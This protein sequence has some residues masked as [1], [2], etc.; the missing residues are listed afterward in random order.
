MLYSLTSS[1]LEWHPGGAAAILGHAGK[2]CRGTSEGFVSIRHEY[3]YRN[4]GG[5]SHVAT[6]PTPINSTV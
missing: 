6:F 2:V 3:P 4:L 5:V 1:V